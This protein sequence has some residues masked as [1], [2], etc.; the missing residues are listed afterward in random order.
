MS[1]KVNLPSEELR[2][3]YIVDILNYSTDRQI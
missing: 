3:K 2:D 1:I